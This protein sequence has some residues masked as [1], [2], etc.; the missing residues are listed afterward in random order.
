MHSPC[1]VMLLLLGSVAWADLKVPVLYNSPPSR[2]DS[3]KREPQRSVEIIPLRSVQARAVNGQPAVRGH[4]Y[5]GTLQVGM[6]PQEM[7]VIF[8]TSSGHLILPGT[9]C[10]DV[11]CTEHR[12][13]QSQKSEVAYDIN[14][15]GL[16]LVEGQRWA[17]KGTTRDFLTIDFTQVDLGEG[18][19]KGFV[20]QDKVCLSG[21]SCADVGVVEL[22]RMSEVPF[23][24]MPHDGILGL[25]LGGLIAGPGLN[26][27]ERWATTSGK[28][29]E[30]GMHLGAAGGE[31]IFGGHDPKRL[32]APLRWFPVAL[33]EE[34]YWAVWIREVRV[35]NVTIDACAGG[36][37]GIVDTASSKLGVPLPMAPRLTA[38]LASAPEAGAGC[39]G[40][41]LDLELGGFSLTLR[42][43]DYADESCAPDLAPLPLPDPPFGGV[44]TLGEA[45][46]RRYYAAFDWET[47]R[48]GFSPLAG[49]FV[50]LGSP[51]P[52]A[53]GRP[54]PE[55]EAAEQIILL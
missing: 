34:G 53:V 50:R 9:R 55:V 36:C 38:A 13:Y 20:V 7:D 22:T 42:A 48:V 11:A 35:G 29:R 25:G 33:P 39:R 8:D 47:K 52:R 19:A 45:V 40:P 31:I 54:T 44:Y 41:D 4:F 12:R 51:A 21:G 23:R 6:P 18:Q 2:G 26:F 28:A 14:L 5:T 43:A 27:L 15:N 46:L 30:F 32:A 17:S 24:A 37:R 16:P 1:K 3:L 10:K 49:R